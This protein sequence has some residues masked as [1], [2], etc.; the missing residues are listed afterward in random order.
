MKHQKISKIQKEKIAAEYLNGDASYQELE[1]RYGICTRTLQ[2]W[3]HKYKQGY[4]MI[5]MPKMIRRSEPAK[6]MPADVKQLQEELNKARLHNLL[7]EELLD[8]GKEKYGID[9]R[10][11]TGAKQS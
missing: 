1:I 9:L 5:T 2:R 4:R 6:T 7:L 11:K 3:V 8:I 10:K